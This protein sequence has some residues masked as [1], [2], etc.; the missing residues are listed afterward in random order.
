MIAIQPR[1][2]PV[3]FHCLPPVM[4]FPPDREEDGASDFEALVICLSWVPSVGD[5]MLAQGGQRLH[6]EGGR[7]ALFPWALN[8]GTSWARHLFGVRANRVL[9]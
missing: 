6:M 4:S 5:G 7:R 9:M 2:P 3:Y 8:P 1:S